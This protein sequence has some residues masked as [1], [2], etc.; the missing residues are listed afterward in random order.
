MW[1]GGGCH[2][3]DKSLYLVQVPYL[4]GLS[5]GCLLCSTGKSNACFIG[6]NDMGTRLEDLFYSPGCEAGLLLEVGHLGISPRPPIPRQGGVP[7]AVLPPLSAARSPCT[8][9]WASF[10][11]SWGSL[12]HTQGRSLIPCLTALY[13]QLLCPGKFGHDFKEAI[14]I[15]KTNVST[16]PRR[17]PRVQQVATLFAPALPN[18]NSSSFQLGNNEFLPVEAPSSLVASSFPSCVTQQRQ[19]TWPI[20]NTF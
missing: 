7:V 16:V 8:S 2:S 9:C 18:L 1:E 19:S 17:L 14:M 5:L 3:D 6:H 11:G 4:A 15:Q 10:A 12:R 13:V 20:R